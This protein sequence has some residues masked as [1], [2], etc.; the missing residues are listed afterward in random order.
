MS[1]GA[2]TF[3][4]LKHLGDEFVNLTYRS[5]VDQT[6]SSILQLAENNAGY[7][8]QTPQLEG[9]GNMVVFGGGWSSRPP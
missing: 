9:N 7:R 3:F 8:D 4:M 1:N 5:L 2:F 6:G